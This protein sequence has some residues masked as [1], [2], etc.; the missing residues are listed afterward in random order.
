MLKYLVLLGIGYAVY[1]IVKNGAYVAL[2]QFRQKDD[3]EIQSDL[4]KCEQCDRYIGKEISIRKK[5]KIFC[6]NECAD[7][8]F[9]SKWD[10]FLFD[11]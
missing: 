4:I 3:L 9:E 10:F 2:E 1:K 6:S 7:K 8:F 5:S 11:H